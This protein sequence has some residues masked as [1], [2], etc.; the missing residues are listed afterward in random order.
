MQNKPPYTR[1]PSDE[2][3]TLFRR[4]VTSFHS[5]NIIYTRSHPFS[6]RSLL[7]GFC[8]FLD[9]CTVLFNK[10]IKQRI[11][12][13]LRNSVKIKLMTLLRWHRGDMCDFYF[14]QFYFAL[15]FF[16]SC[17]WDTKLC[18]R[19]NNSWPQLSILCARDN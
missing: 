9:I 5:R 7:R 14:L 10:E 3:S 2:I 15:H 4:G 11:I 1:S 18:A 19:L 13:Y 8:I 17:A 6:T 12:P 16:K